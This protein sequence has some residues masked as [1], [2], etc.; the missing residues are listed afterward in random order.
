VFL[1][2]VRV[3]A[4]VVQVRDTESAEEVGEV[5]TSFFDIEGVLIIDVLYYCRKNMRGGELSA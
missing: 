3:N 1:P 5:I 4:D 2:G